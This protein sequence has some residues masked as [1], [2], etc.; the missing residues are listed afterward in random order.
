MAGGALYAAAK[1][2]LDSLTRSWAVQ[3]ATRGVR[4]VAVAPGPI[5]TPIA[6]HQGLDPD[7]IDALRQTL[8]EHVPL[9]R[10]GRP[11]EVAFWIIQLAR[12]EAAFT[13][14]VV[15]PVDGGAVVG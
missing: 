2:A 1:A 12:P 13:T 9:R 4:V 6:S 14:G 11:E 8:V 10:I 5:S 15:L 3:L 7:Q